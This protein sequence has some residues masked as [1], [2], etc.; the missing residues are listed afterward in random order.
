MGNGRVNGMTVPEGAE[1]V[2]WG[3]ADGSFTV[4]ICDSEG[5]AIEP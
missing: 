1:A 5:N 2:L 4:Q 3:Q